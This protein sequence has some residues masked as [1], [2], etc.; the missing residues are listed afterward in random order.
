MRTNKMLLN[1]AFAS[2]LSISG[3]TA[4]AGHS[5]APEPGMPISTSNLKILGVTSCLPK[6]KE[7]KCGVDTSPENNKRC[8]RYI[9]SEGDEVYKLVKSE[10]ELQDIF[11]ISGAHGSLTLGSA[12][13][14][15]TEGHFKNSQS[16]NNRKMSLI[17]YYRF[18]INVALSPEV[19]ADSGM[20]SPD[21]LNTCGDAYIAQA[22]G[23]I[24]VIAEIEVE[25][26]SVED[27]LEAKVAMTAK[28]GT[29]VELGGA[30]DFLSD[31]SD[32]INKVSMYFRQEGGNAMEIT[33]AVKADSM[34]GCN[35]KK[36]KVVREG[37]GE[38]VKREDANEEAGLAKCEDLVKELK[39]Y[40]STLATKY[41]FRDHPAEDMAKVLLHYSGAEPVAY[42]NRAAPTI[43]MP[44]QNIMREIIRKKKGLEG[45]SFELGDTI[46]EIPEASKLRNSLYAL[47]TKVDDVISS[48]DPSKVQYNRCFGT[49]P[50]LVDCTNALV[51]A[52]NDVSN[53]FASLAMKDYK[54]VK[55][56]LSYT[57]SNVA[58]LSKLDGEV[59]GNY[60]PEEASCNM[61][62]ASIGGDTYQLYCPKF[63]FGYPTP[64]VTP[65]SVVVDFD[66][67][68]DG[69]PMIS[70]LEVS[71]LS[72]CTTASEGDKPVA[73]GKRTCAKIDYNGEMIP[74]LNPKTHAPKKSSWKWMPKTAKITPLPGKKSGNLFDDDYTIHAWTI[75]S[76]YDGYVDWEKDLSDK[77]AENKDSGKTDVDREERTH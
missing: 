9:Q 34:L 12:S 29:N 60:Y 11:G 36:K 42:G 66:E 45:L 67:D 61:Y 6:F 23:G 19:L 26:D 54:R 59:S 39:H 22:Q 47:K 63:D 30:L 49:T 46:S 5:L 73:K 41:A 37:E 62:K 7:Y 69:D 27:E 15:I 24:L 13:L 76:N 16:K 57:V 32:K 31:N 40:T 18:G 51:Q 20:I 1:L 75:T 33:N 77:L 55:P 50:N 48:M 74:N 43:D 72:T 68:S 2:A 52:R 25:F 70:D 4:I 64:T 10:K 17:Y 71:S 44:T 8:Y 35:F 21:L 65:G 14:N 3:G 53:L 38:L 28:Y 56:T 58:L